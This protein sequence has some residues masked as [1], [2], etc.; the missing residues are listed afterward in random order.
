MKITKLKTF[1][2]DAARAN[3]V[4]VKIFTDEGV[5]GVGEGTIEMGEKTLAARILEMEPY[6]VGKDPFQSEHHTLTLLRDSYWR[7]GVYNRSAIAAIDGALL[8]IKGKA[9]G[10][11]VYELLGGKQRDTIRCY[12][13]GWFSGAETPDDFA[14]LAKETVARGFQ[15][16]KWDPFG[17]AW[18]YQSRRERHQA[19]DIVAAVRDAIG[20]DVDLMIEGHG[21]FDVA[22]ATV[23]A[24]DLAPFDPAFFEEPV[25]PDSLDAL[26]AVRRKSPV[27]IAAGERCFEMA[28]FSEMLAKDAVD[29]LQ[30]DI[31][32]VGGISAA[33]AIAAMAHARFIPVAPH[34]PLGPV[35]NAMT[36]SF[37]ATVPNITWL[38]TS[39]RDVPWRGVVTNE[40]VT[41]ENGHMVIPDR[42]GLGID[43]DEEACAAHPYRHYTNNHYDGRVT[44]VRSASS[45][46][47]F[48]AVQPENQE[49]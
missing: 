23:I 3:Y 4:F 43:I 47:Y 38:E 26:A 9:M 34:N 31:T 7:L 11:P 30:P 13:N 12:A 18:L 2:V 1:V 35:A 22:T 42:P 24:R 20:N 45:V 8:D 6:L 27:P 16:L 15:A 5:T 32:H 48:D 41:I 14:R 25:P 39:V 29:I 33:R 46:A 10:V 19:L 40:K 17:S 28:R 21:R 44:Q 37:A 36:L 49:T